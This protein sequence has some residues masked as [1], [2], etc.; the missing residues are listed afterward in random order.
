MPAR[1]EGHRH[2]AVTCAAALA[3]AL[4]FSRAAG[5][6]LADEAAPLET[7]IVS[8]SL[9]NVRKEEVF[10]SR[11]AEGFWVPLDVLTEFGLELPS[12][13]TRD[14]RGKPHVRLD[15]VTGLESSFDEATLTLTLVA[16]PA[17][18]LPQEIDLTR[19]KLLEITPSTSI[20]G[21]L[22]YHYSVEQTTGSSPV[23][24]LSLTASLAS[25]G[26]LLRSEHDATYNQ[27]DVQHY[28]I[29]STLQRDWPAPMLR[30][31]LG[32]VR[33]SAGEFSRTFDLGGI[34]FGRAFDLRP[35][36]VTSPTAQLVGVT[37]VPA[38]AEIYVNG[39]RV[40]T[41]ELRPGTFDLRNLSDFAGLRQ[42][43][44]VVRDAS[45][46]RDRLKVPYYFTDTLL[47]QG[48]TDFNL[49]WGAQRPDPFSDTYGSAA[50]SG[51]VVHGLTDS[52]T[53]GVAGQSAQAYRYAGAQAGWRMP[54]LG[55]LTAAVGW[56]R[57]EE[58]AS[59]LARKVSWSYTRD[60][61]TL[62]ALWRAYDQSFS[63]QPPAPF[64]GP[65]Q[66]LTLPPLSREY[67]VG[68]DQGITRHVL[69][70][71]VATDRRYALDSRPERQYSAQLSIGL[72]G[73]GTL[74]VAALQTR[75]G[76]LRLN[77]GSISFS[78]NLDDRRYVQ[79]DAR[80][81]PGK[82]DEYTAQVAQSVPEG[83]GVGWSLRAD[84]DDTTRNGEVSGT[85]R[86]ARGVLTGEI[87]ETHQL[88]GGRDI[89]GKRVGMDGSVACVGARCELGRPVVDSF[90]VVDLAGIPD[91]RVFRNNQEIGRTNAKGELFISDLPAL[92]ENEIRFDDSEVPIS[93]SLSTNKVTVVPAVGAGLRVSFDLR[94]LSSAAGTL[95]AK[96][97]EGPKPIENIE[98]T[99]RSERT[100]EVKLRTGRDGRFEIGQIETGRYHLAAPLAEGQCGVY[101]DIPEKRPSVL[102]L[103][104]LTCEI[105][106]Y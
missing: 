31:I 95:R 100:D 75:R 91:V 23:H 80:R 83:Q 58:R 27:G 81:N 92:T 46:I 56:Q 11:E 22:N 106:A 18:F 57:D 32:D 36:F 16:D 6:D 65:L 84:A 26:W 62:R 13:S 53:L 55:V 96:T 82:Q 30:L 14:I 85:W 8:V 45:G 44:V 74:T 73:W 3:A 34:S 72:F 52:L 89:V 50:F 29:A 70:S 35:G 101:I 40:A 54:W 87:R 28:R 49:S 77:E 47:A 63:Q 68:W 76:P 93:V 17:L 69:A 5:A 42:V 59:A 60:V 71:L 97:P 51:Y 2:F 10:A 19:S 90:A 79:L 103:G 39:V 86:A 67:A 21:Y 20:S 41:R 48:L 88:A 104:E 98:L 99:L 102:E 66:S 24:D 4:Y 33:A 38:T 61:T 94:K 105:A 15:Q 12:P 64:S 43:E 9:N 25:A 7:V 78:A 37:P 1:P